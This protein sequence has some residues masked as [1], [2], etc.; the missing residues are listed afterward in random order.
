MKNNDKEILY[1]MLGREIDKMIGYGSPFSMFSD[2]IKKFVFAKIDPYVSFFFT[3]DKFEVDMA[4]DYATSEISSKL[5]EFKKQYKNIKK[6]EEN[7]D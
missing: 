2:Q 4:A 7:N 6:G 3:D 1:N 5:E